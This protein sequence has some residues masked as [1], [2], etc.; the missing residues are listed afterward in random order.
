[1]RE[2]LLDYIACPEC[3]G[4]LEGTFETWDGEEAMDGRLTCASC[5]AT[6]PLVRGVPRMNTSMKGLENVARTFGYEWRSFHEGE[7][8]DE[9]VFGRTPE[10]D[11]Q[12]FLEGLGVDEADLADKAVLDAGCGSGR[13]TKQ[14]GQHGAGIVIGVD[15]NDAVEAVWCGEC[16]QRLFVAEVDLFEG[17]GVAKGVPKPLNAGLLQGRV[18]IIIEIVDADDFLAALEQRVGSR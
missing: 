7:F 5:S 3:N 9:T 17:E 10:E 4:D 15:M 14:I 11:W 6:Y 18:V 12:Y 2:V 13:L 1:M 16:F 8:E